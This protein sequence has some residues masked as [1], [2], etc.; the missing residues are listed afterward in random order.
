[1]HLPFSPALVVL[2]RLNRLVR[3]GTLAPDALERALH[4][5][6][7]DAAEDERQKQ[8]REP[9]GHA[10]RQERIEQGGEPHVHGP[11]AEQQ[12]GEQQPRAEA[13]RNAVLLVDH[14]LLAHLRLRER[15]LEREQLATLARLRA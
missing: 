12:R 1:M 11:R 8:R 3:D 10:E 14:E 4:L 9:D 2:Q 7:T 13:E 15:Q 5:R 6:E